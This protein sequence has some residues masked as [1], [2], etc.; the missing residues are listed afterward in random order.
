MRNHAGGDP[1]LFTELDQLRAR[2]TAFE[3][4]LAARVTAQ[5]EA[6]AGLRQRTAELALVNSVQQALASQLDMQGI[7]NVVGEKIREIFAAEAIYIALFDPQSNLISFPYYQLNDAQIVV[8]PR[9]LGEGLT[10][11]V[12]QSRRPLVLGTFQAQLDVGAVINGAP[13]DSYLGVPMVSGGVTVGVVSA[14]SHNEHAYTDA[15]VRLLDTLAGATSVALDNA[16]LFTETT[17]LLAETDRRAAELAIINSV[18]QALAAELDMQGIVD[19]VGNE[20]R[21]TFNVQTAYIALLDPTG[22]TMHL[23]YTASTDG[24]SSDMTAPQGG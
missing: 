14:Q 5:E 8:E 20:I 9:P 1:D 2:T 12:I 24:E 23:A 16:R 19:I 6:E 3:A 11:L 15:D 21:K 17:R 18:Q 7:V 22:S 4:Q 10:S 13:C